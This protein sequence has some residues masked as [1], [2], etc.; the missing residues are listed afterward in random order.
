MFL[1][2]NTLCHN[3]TALKGQRP[4]KDE[5]P[6][7]DSVTTV[8]TVT[9]A[10]RQFACERDD[11]E[12]PSLLQIGD[13]RMATTTVGTPP[14]SPSSTGRPIA[15]SAPPTHRIGHTQA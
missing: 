8:T 11:L 9:G 2:N 14:A 13:R 12:H 5:R 1:S 6:P 15:T 4:R 7:C 3:V 10:Y